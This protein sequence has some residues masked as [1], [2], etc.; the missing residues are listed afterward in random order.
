MDAP[1]TSGPAPGHAR[2]KL[3]LLYH[4]V[5]GEVASLVDRLETVST[6][7]DAAQQQIQAVADTQQVLPQQL[8]R[9]LTTSL[10]ATAKPIHQQ[11]QQAIQAM[12]DA[13]GTR[14]DHLALEAAQCARITHH[15]ARRMTVIAVII[16][17]AAGVLG[18]LL[19]GLALGQ[20]LIP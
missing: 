4:D 3:D 14:L 19:A 17:G 15:A 8:V 2:T 11:H 16:G 20:W 6:S 7:L 9:H 12:L 10:E 13:T 1:H 18:G 5:L